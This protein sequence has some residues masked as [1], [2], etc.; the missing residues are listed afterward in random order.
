MDELYIDKIETELKRSAI[1]SATSNGG[2]LQ[3]ELNPGHL[4][5]GCSWRLWSKIWMIGSSSKDD[6]DV[7]KRLQ[8]ILQKIPISVDVTGE[9]HDLVIEFE[10]GISLHTFADSN[11]HESWTL[12][13]GFDRMYIAGPGRLWSAFNKEDAERKT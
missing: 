13:F 1:R 9:F 12:A 6:A 10:N 4:A 11:E 7:A 8:E 5:V 3:I 2:Y